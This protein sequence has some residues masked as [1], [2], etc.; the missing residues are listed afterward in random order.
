MYYSFNT[1][2]M[3]LLSRYMNIY[4]G[5]IFRIFY[6]LTESESNQLKINTVAKHDK[7]I[8]FNFVT[9]NADLIYKKLQLNKQK[10]KIRKIQI[11]KSYLRNCE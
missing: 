11:L 2:L 7:L 8:C 10:R 9:F 4:Y 5:V 1:I 6:R 3:F